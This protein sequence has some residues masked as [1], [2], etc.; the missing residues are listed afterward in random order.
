MR[1]VIPVAI[2]AGNVPVTFAV[3]SYAGTV[4][5]T[6]LSDPDQAPDVDTLTAALRQE[7]PPTPG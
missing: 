3:L 6:V 4:W 1:A 7:L 5:L 2:T